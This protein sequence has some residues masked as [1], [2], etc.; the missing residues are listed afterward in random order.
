MAAMMKFEFSEIEVAGVV[1]PIDGYALIEYKPRAIRRH[2]PTIVL[3]GYE[4]G[5]SFPPKAAELA[6]GPTEDKNCSWL[7]GLNFAVREYLFTKR[8]QAMIDQW[9]EEAEDRREAAREAH[10]EFLRGA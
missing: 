1:L 3:N 2:M 7:T 5:D 9:D 4:P 10:A 6:L 8:H